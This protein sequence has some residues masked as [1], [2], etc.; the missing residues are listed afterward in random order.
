MAANRKLLAAAVV[1]AAAV[2]GVTGCSSDGG[3]D[4]FKGKSADQI[5]KK[6]IN[7][8]K[9]AGSFKVTGKGEQQ[10]KPMQVDFA[11]AKSD[12]CQGKTGSPSTG[13]G[14]ILVSGKSSYFKGDDKFWKSTGSSAL[15]AKLKGRWMKSPQGQT[16]KTCDR[17][18][19]FESKGLKGLERG[20]DAE[21]DGKKTAVLTKKDGGQTVTYHVALDGKPYFLQIDK[22]GGDDPVKLNF[23]DYGKPVVVKAPAADDVVEQD[24]LKKLMGS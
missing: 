23:S 19:M 17:D 7:A 10:G 9:G 18:Q 21:I 1:C 5:A 15:G 11:V 13:I 2:V 24:D 20:D 8:S 3:N 16:A 12:D 14:E 4:P 6:A 22:K